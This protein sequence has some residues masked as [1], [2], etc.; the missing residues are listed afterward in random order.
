M[1]QECS[2]KTERCEG[3][4]TG[5]DGSKEWKKIHAAVEQI[6]CE[7][8]KDTGKKLMI[9][10]HDIVNAKLGK[11]IF[12]KPNFKHHVSQIKCICDKTGVC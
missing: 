2:I 11:P 3:K 10:A 7:T 4:C 8:C 12:D 9:F 5:Y 6:G 1:S